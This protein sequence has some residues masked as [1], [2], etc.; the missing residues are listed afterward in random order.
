VGNDQDQGRS[1][2]IQAIL[3]SQNGDRQIAVGK[4]ACVDETV[5][6]EAMVEDPSDLPDFAEPPINESALSIQFQPISSFGIPHFGLYWQTI[7]KDFERFQVVPTVEAATEQFSKPSPARLNLQLLSQPE[8]RCWYL[9]RG[10]DRLVQV[11]RD[12]FIHNW[13]QVDGTEKYPRYPVIRAAL[14]AHW[15]GFLEFLRSERMGSPE[16][17]QCEVTY[18]NHVEYDKE[19][20]DFGRL[21]HVIAPWHGKHSGTFLPD[22]EAVGIEAHYR[23]PKELGRLHISVAPVFRGRDSKEVLQISL[24]ARGAPASSLTDDIFAW[25]DFGRQWV[26]RGFADFTAESI[27]RLWGRKK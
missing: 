17:N 11:Q 4:C 14:Y 8:I 3:L 25:L 23:L 22:P 10:G 24:T 19:W 26:V 27:Q 9:N 18:V 5:T 6:L 15:T 2:E 21:G 16:V 20:S 13:R 7:R 12:R 1:D